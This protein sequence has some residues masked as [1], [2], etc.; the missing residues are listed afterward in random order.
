MLTTGKF[1]F[2]SDP[3]F[4]EARQMPALTLSSTI[5]LYFRAY[6]PNVPAHHHGKPQN[7]SPRSGVKWVQVPPT[8]ISEKKSPFQEDQEVPS[9]P[10]RAWSHQ[11][12]GQMGACPPFPWKPIVLGKPSYVYFGVRRVVHFRHL[13]AVPCIGDA[14]RDC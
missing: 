7:F 5:K 13:P 2:G 9:A 12:K 8:D 11:R 6:H 1:I 10:W 3:G 14:G 4:G